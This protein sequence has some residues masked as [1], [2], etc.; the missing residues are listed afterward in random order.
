MYLFKKKALFSALVLI[1]GITIITNE[2]FAQQKADSAA[3]ISG[4]VVKAMSGT[5]LSGINVQ[6]KELDKKATTDDQ[7]MYRFEN[8]KPGTYTLEVKADGYKPWSKKVTLTA[9]GKTVD[10]KLEPSM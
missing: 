10:V 7:G 1:I 5:A 2:S 3:T 8:L 4:K 9:D 6:L